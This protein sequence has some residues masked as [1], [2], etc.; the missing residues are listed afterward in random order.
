MY[1]DDEK[2]RRA[3]KKKYMLLGLLA[4]A[5]MVLLGRLLYLNYI[6]SKDH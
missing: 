4:W 6:A 1:N 5:V 2:I 3:W